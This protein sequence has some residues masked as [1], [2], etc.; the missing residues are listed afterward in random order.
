MKIRNLCI[1][2]NWFT[3]G[4]NDAYNKLLTMADGEELEKVLDKMANCIYWNST[5]YSLYGN[6]LK[7]NEDLQKIKNI[8]IEDACR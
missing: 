2:N 4:T 7:V 6:V 1:E 8:I 5:E 3:L